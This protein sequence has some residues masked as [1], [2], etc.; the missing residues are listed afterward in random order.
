LLSPDLAIVSDQRN[1]AKQYQ[2]L[3][4]FTMNAY[5]LSWPSAW[6]RTMP[7]YR[8]PARFSKKVASSTSGTSHRRSE[9]LTISDGVARVLT[10]LGRMGIDRQDVIV[11]TNVRTRLDGLPPSGERAPEDPGAAVYW[12][13]WTGA[14]HV[15]AIDLYQRVADNLAAIAASLEA[16]RAVERHGGAFILERAFTGFTAL[17]APGPSREWWEVLEV[18]R[19]APLDVITLAYRRLASERHPDKPQGSHNAMA[20]LNKAFEQAKESCS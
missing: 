4:G 11:S 10:E 12:Q 3:L 2:H 6:P 13:E 16:L 9:D 5:P 7:A 19:T 17:P 18:E 1:C 20:E 8:R 14:R 15:I